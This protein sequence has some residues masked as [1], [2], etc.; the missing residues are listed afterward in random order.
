MYSV[1]ILRSTRTQGYYVGYSGN[2]QRRLAEHNRGKVRS[3]RRQVPFEVIY[4]EGFGSEAEARRRDGAIKR[5]KSRKYIDRLVKNAL[6]AQLDRA[7]PCG[8]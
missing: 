2:V 4:P 8:G 7:Q 3:T 6:V 5:Q 1:Y